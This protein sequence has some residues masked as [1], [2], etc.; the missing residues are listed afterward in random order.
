MDRRPIGAQARVPPF[1]SEEVKPAG[2]LRDVLES[3]LVSSHFF[4]CSCVDFITRASSMKAALFPEVLIFPFGPW[5]RCCFP[6]AAK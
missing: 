4:Y 6:I 5:H 3:G 2:L 1:A